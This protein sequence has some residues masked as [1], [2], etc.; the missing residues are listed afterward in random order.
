M[1]VA[2]FPRFRRMAFPQELLQLRRGKG[3]SQQALA[4]AT[5]IHVTQIK[6]YEGGSA[7]P[8]MEAL[9]KMAIA[10]DCTTDQLVFDPSER[11]I[12]D[13]LKMQF[14]AA[15]RLPEEE[16]KIARALLEGLIL[17]HEA[18]RWERSAG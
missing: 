1:P 7:Q 3:M 2:R 9:K 15:S 13:D 12:A 6:R 14:E 11:K 16:R 17:K 4:D 18:K 8:S 10:L 5:G